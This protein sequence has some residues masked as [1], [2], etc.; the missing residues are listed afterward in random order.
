MKPRPESSRGITG[1]REAS[2][3]F[4]SQ[5]PPLGHLGLL[6]D[7]EGRWG[8]VSGCAID[9]CPSASRASSS[10]RKVTCGGGLPRPVRQRQLS[11]AVCAVGKLPE[12]SPF[13]ALVAGK[14]GPGPDKSQPADQVLIRLASPWTT[15]L[16]LHQAPPAA[17]S[18]GPQAE[19]DV[20]RPDFSFHRLQR[21]LAASLS[22]GPAGVVPSR[23]P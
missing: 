22:G 1:Q 2:R 20:Q 10:R 23:S 15:P 16:P 14:T 3:Q 4:D 18:S 17:S 7:R 11:T 5:L 6:T 21:C 8:K 19:P 13:P 12:R 9:L